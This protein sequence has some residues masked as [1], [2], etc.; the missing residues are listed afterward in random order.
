MIAPA[1]G[2]FFDIIQTFLDARLFMIR[3]IT[4]L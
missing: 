3:E 2:Q 1:Q 4:R